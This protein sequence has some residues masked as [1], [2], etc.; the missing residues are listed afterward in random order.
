VTT[1]NSVIPKILIQ[2]FESGDG[3]TGVAY[4]GLSKGVRDPGVSSPLRGLIYKDTKSG[5]EPGA[6]DGGLFD[7]GATMGTDFFPQLASVWISLPNASAI[8]LI[9][10]DP[11]GVEF[12]VA[13]VSANTLVVSSISES[14]YCLP[15]WKF[16]VVATGTLNGDGAIYL[17]FN[18][19]LKPLKNTSFAANM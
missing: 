6:I 2:T 4:T 8:K 1:F 18:E 19:W 3:C 5:S 14:W 15:G 10:I 17:I 13:S 9:A 11:D 12:E 16:K 7:L